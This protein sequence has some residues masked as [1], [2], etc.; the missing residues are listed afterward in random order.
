MTAI[1]I[2][3]LLFFMMAMGVPVGFAMGVS[4]AV[5]LYAVG[6]WDML[7]GVLETVPL[8]TVSSYEMIT[9]P[10]FLLMAE[11]V[12]KSG[13]ADDLF[14]AAAAWVGSLRGGLGM[15]TAI[16]GAGFGAICGTSTAAAATLSATSLPAMIKHG[17]EPKMAAGVVAISGTLAMLIPPSVVLIIYG[18]LAEANIGRLLIAGIIPG[19]LIALTIMLTVYILATLKPSSAPVSPRKTLSEK[20]HVLKVVGPMLVLMMM[21]TGVIYTGVATPTE[22][23]ALGAFGALLIAL[24]RRKA[25]ASVVLDAAKQAAQGTCMIAM[26]LMGASIFGYFFTLTSVTQD[27]V[28]WVGGLHMQPWLIMLGVFAVYIILGAFMDQ[29][30]ILVLT[31]PV[32]LPVVIALGYDPIWFGVLVIVIA[33]VGL[34]TPP[35]GLNCFV[36]AFYARRPVTEVFAGIWPHV[37][38][39]LV[40]IGLLLAFPQIV[41]WLPSMMK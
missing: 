4:G 18:L 7:L 3:L 25:T 21:V 33:E 24:L 15:A 37:L 6:N 1:S 16:A 28:Q 20:I 11:L 29:I 9:I 19:L 14:D 23:S 5:G 30:A 32:V 2:T 17:Y 34:L 26:I 22:A 8:S 38:A 40:A 27:L 39:H 36:V 13:I 10:M 12:L 35:M 41:L 31:V